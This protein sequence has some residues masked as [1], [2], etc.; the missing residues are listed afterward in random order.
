V[1]SVG[2]EWLRHF[3]S[4]NVRFSF[5]SICRS[6]EVLSGW[7]WMWMFFCVSRVS[8]VCQLWDLEV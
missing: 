3:S 2:V 1:L 6:F 5:L 7:M 8:I 4:I